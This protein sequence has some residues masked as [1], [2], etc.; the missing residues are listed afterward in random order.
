[1]TR[2]GEPEC[3]DR[4][5]DTIRHAAVNSLAAGRGKRSTGT[6]RSP[7]RSKPDVLRAHTAHQAPS[8]P[9]PS[10][11]SARLSA[12]AALLTV[13]VRTSAAKSHSGVSAR[14][15]RASAD[16]GA[17]TIL[18]GQAPS[19]RGR[20]RPPRPGCLIPCRPVSPVSLPGRTEPRCCYAFCYS[21]R[22]AKALSPLRKGLDLRKLVAGEGFEPSTS[23][24]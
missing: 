24:L 15:S 9:A 1:M 11:R 5:A 23:G 6:S 20:Q 13:S 4:D 22:N 2:H 19:D 17:P 3:G 10:R 16:A 7:G 14:S 12:R 21:V 8:T 18:L